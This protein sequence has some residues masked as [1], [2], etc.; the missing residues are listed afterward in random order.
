MEL[1]QQ[2]LIGILLMIIL[3]Y[4]GFIQFHPIT[5][6]IQGDGYESDEEIVVKRRKR[7]THEKSRD[8][9]ITPITEI[10][11]SKAVRFGEN[12]Q[13][14]ENPKPWGSMYGGGDADDPEYIQRSIMN[15]LNQHHP[16]ILTPA[17]F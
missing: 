5:H 7:H 12:I 16:S 8:R 11:Q 3:Y 14:L 10:L 4:L 2:I 15:E 9:M 1:V 13:E 6:F 17:P